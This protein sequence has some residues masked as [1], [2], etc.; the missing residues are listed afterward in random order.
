VKNGI[1]ALDI[2]EVSAEKSGKR[3]DKVGAKGTWLS[4]SNSARE[5]ARRKLCPF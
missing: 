2:F 5:K 3:K 4:E 1:P